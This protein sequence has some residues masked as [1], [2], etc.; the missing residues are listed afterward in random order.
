MTRW[1]ET[2]KL[3]KLDSDKLELQEILL[4]LQEILLTMY[5]DTPLGVMQPTTPFI[6]HP[7]LKT[8]LTIIYNVAAGYIRLPCGEVY[9]Y[10][11][12]CVANLLAILEVIVT[13]QL[14]D[15]K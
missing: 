13:H 8:L 10:S 15:Y 14:E 4:E 12:E 3:V 7:D 11:D 1:W 9:K 6:S 5:M 2:L